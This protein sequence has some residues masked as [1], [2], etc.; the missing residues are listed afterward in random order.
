MIREDGEPFDALIAPF[1]L[2]LP[3]SLN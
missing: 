2:S 1:V 3:Y